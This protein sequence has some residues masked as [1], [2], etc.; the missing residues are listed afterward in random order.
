MREGT[1]SD[2]EGYAY[3]IVT[4]HSRDGEREGEGE[5]ARR[6]PSECDREKERALHRTAFMATEGESPLEQ[7]EQEDREQCRQTGKRQKWANVIHEKHTR[8]R[9]ERGHFTLCATRA[10]RDR[11]TETMRGGGGGGGGGGETW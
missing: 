1:T 9:R 11:P 2:R 10:K 3:V 4:T 7:Q 5:R 8:D 6:S